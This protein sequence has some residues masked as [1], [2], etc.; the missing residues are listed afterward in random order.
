MTDEAKAVIE[1]VEAE[2][3]AA[4]VARKANKKEAV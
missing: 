3:K 1:R 2:E 4:R